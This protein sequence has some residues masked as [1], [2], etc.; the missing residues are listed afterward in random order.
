MVRKAAFKLSEGHSLIPHTHRASWT[1][2]YPNLATFQN[3]VE[4]CHEV[5]L[6]RIGR[7]GKRKM[8]ATNLLVFVSHCPRGIKN[9]QMNE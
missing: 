7:E 3:L 2:K 9:E 6:D 8:D 4:L 1:F 5:F